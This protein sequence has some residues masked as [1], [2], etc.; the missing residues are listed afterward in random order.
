MWKTYT[1]PRTIE[2]ALAILATEPGKARVVAGGTDLV[3]LL[4]RGEARATCL[5]DV[6]AI[7]A[8][9]GIEQDGEYIPVGAAVTHAELASSP[10]V[11]AGA[12]L[13]ADAADEIASP[14]IRAVATIGGNVVNAQPAADT[15]LA[16]LALGAEAQV[17]GP[18]GA[19]WLKLEELYQGAG[20]STVDSTTQL[21]SA[22]RFRP[23]PAAAGSA[24]RRLGKCKSIAL[25]VLCAA[26]VVE[27]EGQRF[28][29]ASIALGPVAPRPY[30]ASTA[31]AW[32]VG[33]P[34]NA[35][36]IAHAARMTQEDTEPRDSLLRCAAAYRKEMV[37]T[38]VK[39]T[40]EAATRSAPGGAEMML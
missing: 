31:E 33:Q 38:L 24:Y 37:F 28:S 5:V 10:I 39:C 20:V 30:R 4:Q 27:L 3:L 23:L 2:E 9:R 11:R 18:G 22:F 34:A 25:P 7:E 16:L 8:L 29:S 17:V 40:L 19:T 6:T 1:R 21:V 13:L 32:L 14:E 15:A 12:H 35:D 26:T 36:G